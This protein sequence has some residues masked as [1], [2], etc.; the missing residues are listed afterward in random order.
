[1]KNFSRRTFSVLAGVLFVFSALLAPQSAAAYGGSWGHDQPYT[2]AV[3]ITSS[4]ASMFANP[5]WC[6]S[7]LIRY[8]YAG[9][10]IGVRRDHNAYGTYVTNNGFWLML[11][12]QYGSWGFL[13]PQSTSRPYPGS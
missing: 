4:S 9:Q 3:T 13:H 10:R 2:D 11:D 1:M 12:Y 6:P 8:K 5:C 7:Y